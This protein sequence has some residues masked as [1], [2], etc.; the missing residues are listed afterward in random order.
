M[1]M[2]YRESAGSFHFKPSSETRRHLPDDRNLRSIKLSST[3]DLFLP[4]KNESNTRPNNPQLPVAIHL[5]LSRTGSIPVILDRI[6]KLAEAI[7]CITRIHPSVV[8]SIS[9]I[10]ILTHF[11][12]KLTSVDDFSL[13][14]HAGA[15]FGKWYLHSQR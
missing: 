5:I 13:L 14:G 4:L 8:T 11:K 10:N 12:T 3:F 2:L 6:I 7:I 15:S 1:R 9:C